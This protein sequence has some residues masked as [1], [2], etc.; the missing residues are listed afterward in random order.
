[1]NLRPCARVPLRSKLNTAPQPRG[2]S[3]CRERV[4]RML[5]QLRIADRCRPTGAPRR[6][7]TIRRALSTWRRH[8]QRQRLDALQD[9]E[10][11]ERRH[12]RAEVAH[13]LA[14]RA[15]QERRGRRLLGE[16]HV[17]EAG[18]RLGQRRELAAR[19]RAV[20][21]ESPRIDQHAADHDAVAGEEL[22]RRVEHEVGAVLERPH[23]IRRGERRIDQE[24]QA[25]LVR[26]RRHARDVEHVEARIAE[27]LAEQQP[28]L[29]T[30][31]GAP[32]VE[33]RGSTN[34]VVDAEA[35]QRVVEQ[36]VRA[37][38][39]RA[40]RDDVRC[41]RPAASRSRDAAPPARS[42]SRSRRRRLRAR[43]CAPR[44][45]RRSDS[46]C[47]NRRAPRAPC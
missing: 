8:A 9:L 23:Q 31:R 34:V 38:V 29:G 47:A 30:D 7:A 14:P 39:E 3:C 13:A 26:E 16:H 25:V 41:P 2:S 6:N 22:R 17:V 24:R 42:R 45:P 35:R 28:R 12:A 27:R 46:R 1:M 4:I 20:P 19:L 15:Q 10:R 44:A 32:R 40:R 33:S 43:R 18:V 36:V 37:A 5:R 21:V 11:G